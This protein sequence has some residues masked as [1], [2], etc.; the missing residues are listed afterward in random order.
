[1]DEIHRKLSDDATVI[2][3][4]NF[5]G[6]ELWRIARTYRTEDPKKLPVL[7]NAWFGDHFD[8]DK[9]PLLAM[10]SGSSLNFYPQMG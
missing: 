5:S 7:V 6:I 9:M 4:T 8:L 3:Q 2:W 1:M 10:P